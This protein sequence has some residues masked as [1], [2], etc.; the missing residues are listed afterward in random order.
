MQ[1]SRLSL[2]TLSLSRVEGGQVKEGVAD[3]ESSTE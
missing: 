3:E 1:G 2:K